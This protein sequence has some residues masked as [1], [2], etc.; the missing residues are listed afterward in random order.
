[1]PLATYSIE[2]LRFH[3]V[4]KL[5]HGLIYQS[6]RGLFITASASFLLG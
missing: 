4:I 2:L 3:Y 5:P 1:M 6:M